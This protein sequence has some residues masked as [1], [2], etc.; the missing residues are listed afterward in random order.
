MGEIIAVV[1][2]KGGTGK[3]TFTSNIGFALASLGKKVL[4]L[5]CDITLRNLDLALGLSDSGPDG[6]FR[7]DGRPLHPGGGGGAPSQVPLPVP[8]GGALGF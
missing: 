2:G 4:C 8:A 6:F 3:T 1:S 7:R 5:D